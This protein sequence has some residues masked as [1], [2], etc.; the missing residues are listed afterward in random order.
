MLY[1]APVWNKPVSQVG[2]SRNVF[3]S[4][5]FG[6][7]VLFR[8]MSRLLIWVF[9]LVVEPPVHDTPIHAVTAEQARVRDC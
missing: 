3:L 6:N 7:M 8:E 4:S 9:V 2:S 5:L 1:T